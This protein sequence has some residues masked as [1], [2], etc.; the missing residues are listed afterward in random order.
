MRNMFGGL[1]GCMIALTA[2]LAAG[3]AVAEDG[4]AYPQHPTRIV[5]PYAAG[6]STDAIA[7]LV[8]KELTE[9][10][11]QSFYVENKPG[12]GGVIAHD[13][14]SKA[15]LDGSTL[16]FSA[17]GP[18]TVTPH[19]YQSLPYRPIDDFAPVKLIAT[20]PL[21]LVVN[22]KV[23]ADTVQQLL[24]L[25]RQQQGKMTYGSFGYGSAAHLAGEM[26]RLREH[27]DIVHV[28]FK[29][30]APALTALM[31]G[32]IDMMFDVLVTALPQVQAG[33]LRALAVTSLK[34]SPLAPALPTMEEVGLP[35]FEAGTW[36]GLLTRA[37]TSP[38]IITKLSAA[39]DKSLA[40]PDVQAAL[41]A[42]G[43]TVAGSSP[44]QFATFFN[45]EFTKWGAV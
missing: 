43:A 6:G 4:S 44:E 25:A 17:A 24:A 33:N 26:F 35:N 20:S 45:A 8:A 3:S 21:M 11:G 27:V 7:R 34:R 31:G 5:V 29:G 42:Q 13:F 18:L 40:K 39:L 16:L 38:E 32:Q 22:P 12:A 23:K 14:V 41:T 19:T 36:F 15:P 1:S 28:P 10:L 30:S 2:C 9:E 37:G